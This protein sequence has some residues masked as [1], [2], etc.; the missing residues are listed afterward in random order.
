MNLIITCGRHLEAEAA[1][2]ISKILKEL[3]DENPRIEVSH[4]SGIITVITSLDPF[5]A[6]QKIQEKILDEPWSIRYCLRIIPIQEFV[7]TEKENIVNAVLNHADAIM[8]Q[9]TYRITV[10]KRHSM[11]STKEI[12]DAIANKIS[13]KV[14]LEKFDWL[15][16]VEI[17][18]NKT[19][20]S[21]LKE[22]DIISTQKLKRSL[23]E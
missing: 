8:S 17:L 9:N 4:L 23:S 6:V 19:G 7:V 5:F 2:E 20:V 18:G 16:L 15:I 13:S 22:N 10:E 12:I 11:I 3:G 21:V 1:E 14:S